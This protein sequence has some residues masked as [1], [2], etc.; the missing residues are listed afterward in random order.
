MTIYFYQTTTSFSH[1]TE[2]NLHKILLFAVRSNK[3]TTLVV[4]V[5]INSVTGVTFFKMR[6]PQFAMNSVHVPAYVSKEMHRDQ[7]LDGNSRNCIY[8][9][10]KSLNTFPGIVHCEMPPAMTTILCLVLNI[11][12]C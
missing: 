9:C 3:L 1:Y 4:S 2:L 8:N 10:N 5:Y 6:N 12:R 7:Y 11:A